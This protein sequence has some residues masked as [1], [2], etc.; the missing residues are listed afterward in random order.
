M[1]QHREESTVGLIG[2][3]LVGQA[4]AGRLLAAGATVVGH[5][6]DPAAREAAAAAGV[7]VVDSAAEV[8]GRARLVLLS[9]PSSPVVE[10]V[11]WAEGGL[12]DGCSA[13][14]VIV[15]TTT[16]D[17]ADTARQGARLAE[18]GALLVDC[19]LMG[20]SAEIAR[21]EAAGLIGGAG[22]DAWF[23][24][25]LRD[26]AGR[27]F[28]LG[29]CSQGHRA[30]LVVNLVLGLNRLV[31]GEGLGLARRCGMDPAV[32]L[33]I[34]KAGPAY[35][36]VMDTKGPAMLARRF[37]PPVARL[38]QHA[39]DVSLILGLGEEVG[40]RLPLSRL[41]REMLAEA[42]GKGWSALDNAAVA[43]LFLPSAE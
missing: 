13:G 37:E 34:L 35:S 31:L 27:L 25:R 2:L 7:A 1:A 43:E 19:A 30:K 41:H 12:A 38:G 9:L 6:V 15:D 11:L 23:V 18:R 40:A 21:G 5:D 3:G 14:S 26:V 39:K 17:P 16:A 8:G 29:G 36:T 4:L 20:S 10:A 33:D 42:M 32:I 22:A 28:F 24:P